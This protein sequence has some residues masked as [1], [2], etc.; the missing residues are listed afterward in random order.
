MAS[1]GRESRPVRGGGQPVV[2]PEAAGEVVLV[3]PADG[4]PL[5][6]AIVRAGWRLTTGF[7][8]VGYLLPVLSSNGQTTVAYRL[9]EQ[10]AMPS[11]RYMVDHGATTIWERWDAWTEERGF[12]SPAMNSFN[13][14]SLGAVGEWFYRFVLGIE[15]EAG[16]A[17]FSRLTLRP[18]PGGQLSWARGSYRS[19]CGPIATE[20]RDGGVFSFRAEIAPGATASVHIPSSDAHQ[21]RDVNGHGPAAIAR[22]PGAIGVNEAVFEVGPGIHQFGGPTLTEDE[23]G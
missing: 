15:P 17:G 10:A 6:G 21:V 22:F 16:R 9:L 11:W 5:V 20:R 13:H 8:G 19:S 4:P 23:H 18:H 14:Y 12:Q 1:A 3:R 2:S 7:V